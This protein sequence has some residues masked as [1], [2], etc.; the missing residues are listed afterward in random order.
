M[1]KKTF[2]NRDLGYFYIGLII[3]CL[4][5]ANDEPPDMWHPEKYTTKTRATQVQLPEE[6]GITDDF[7]KDLGK[8]LGLTIK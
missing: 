1:K 5:R 4:F 6:S 8:K 7:A 2:R 3:S